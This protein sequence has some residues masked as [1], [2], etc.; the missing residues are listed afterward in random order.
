MLSGAR[1]APLKGVARAA[2]LAGVSLPLA[3]P[4]PLRASGD[5]HVSAPVRGSADTLA[6]PRA[7]F[8]EPRALGLACERLEALTLWAPAQPPPRVQHWRCVSASQLRLR[9]PVVR[10]HESLIDVILS[11][12]PLQRPPRRAR[13]AG[14]AIAGARQPPTQAKERVSPPSCSQM[15]SCPTTMAPTAERDAAARQKAVAAGAVWPRNVRRLSGVG[16]RREAARAGRFGEPR[17]VS[18]TPRERPPRAPPIGVRGERAVPPFRGR[19]LASP[20]ADRRPGGQRAGRQ[21]LRG[22]IAPAANIAGRAAKLPSTLRALRAAPRPRPPP[23]RRAARPPRS[24]PRASSAASSSAH[25]G[26]SARRAAPPATTQAA[27]ERA[28]QPRADRRA[29]ERTFE[30][31]DRSRC[32]RARGVPEALRSI[33]AATRDRTGGDPLRRS[34]GAASPR[35]EAPREASVENLGAA[36]SPPPP[37]R[38]GADDG[39]AAPRT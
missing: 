24:R 5:T 37:A 32:G 26:G 4:S 21:G 39:G 19:V 12:E 31:G 7:V 13:R 8:C 14:R 22:A 36:A 9:H 15:T 11:G 1:A 18:R 38:V 2:V 30:R 29:G 17:A 27:D 10:H 16:S 6:R 23:Q 20:S 28:A 25:P 34:T 35:S 3:R 33:T